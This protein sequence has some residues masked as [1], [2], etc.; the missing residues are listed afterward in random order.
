[1]SV[2]P[3]PTISPP[4]GKKK[5]ATLKGPLPKWPPSLSVFSS[6]AHFGPSGISVPL[7]SVSS[8]LMWRSCKLSLRL[9]PLQQQKKIFFESDKLLPAEKTQNFCECQKARCLLLVELFT[10]FFFFFF[11]FMIHCIFQTLIIASFDQSFVVLNSLKKSSSV[12][13]VIFLSSTGTL[14]HFTAPAHH[15][16]CLQ[17]SPL[18]IH[19]SFFCLG[20][21]RE[22]SYFL[23]IL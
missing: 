14:C 2:S 20:C 1:M 9:P 7:R 23:F 11:F 19:S 16:C 18:Q 21:F 6:S 10:S 15:S 22:I 5:K 17:N 12:S 13:V 3:P 8:D 4:S